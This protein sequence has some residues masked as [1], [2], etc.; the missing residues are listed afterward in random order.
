MMKQINTGQPFDCT[1]AKR[2]G[3][4]TSFQKIARPPKE[5]QEH[6]AAT[7]TDKRRR[8]NA[9][10]YESLV[11][12]QMPDGSMRELYTR[13]ITTFNGEDVIL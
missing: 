3:E 8:R 1:Y 10:A 11:P 6:S 13:L 7:L 12:F 4:L 9:T 5:E 2:N